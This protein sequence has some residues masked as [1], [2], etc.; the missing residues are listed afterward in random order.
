MYK[1]EKG[2]ISY[3]KSTLSAVKIDKQDVE[4]YDSVYLEITTN[5]NGKLTFVT[6]YKAPEQQA[7]E[8]TAITRKL[9]P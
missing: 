8:D 6:V 1:K 5:S 4:K 7:A 9:F 2:V 3:V